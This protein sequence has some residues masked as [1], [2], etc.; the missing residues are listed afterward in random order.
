MPVPRNQLARLDCLDKKSR[1]AETGSEMAEFAIRLSELGDGVHKAR[2]AITPTWLESVLSGTDV[3]ADLEHPPGEF[4]IE[5][6]R[7]GDDLIAKGFAKA[8]LVAECSRCLSDVPLSIATELSLTL[9]AGPAKSANAKPGPD[10]VEIDADELGREY[11]SGNEIVFD[12]IVRDHLLLEMP[13]QPRC[14][15]PPC[16]EW[17]KQYLITAEEAEAMAAAAEG[18]EGHKPIDPRL[19]ALANLKGTPEKN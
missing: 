5:L 11:Y 17:V 7:A 14:E 8:T 13:M 15:D 4:Y 19:A 10:G 2:F 16:P 1:I 9:T 18:A 12:D 3:R 6:Y